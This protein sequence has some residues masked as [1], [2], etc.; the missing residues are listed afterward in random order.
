MLRFVYLFIFN[1]QPFLRDSFFAISFSR[2]SLGICVNVCFMV[3][4]HHTA[5]GLCYEQT[6]TRQTNGNTNQNN[7]NNTNSGTKYDQR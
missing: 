4:L 6:L 5:K 1:F 2:N 7:N 3:S